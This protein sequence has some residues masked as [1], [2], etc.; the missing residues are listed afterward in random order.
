LNGSN[1][2]GSNVISNA[3][4]LPI[5]SNEPNRWVCGI[6]L[7]QKNHIVDGFIDDFRIYNR[8]ITNDEIIAIR[9]SS[10]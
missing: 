9:D 5:T 10:A 7:T 4:N 2:N 1:L 3:N 8:V 6:D